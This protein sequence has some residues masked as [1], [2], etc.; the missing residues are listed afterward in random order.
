LSS[1]VVVLSAQLT[2]FPLSAGVPRVFRLPSDMSPMQSQDGSCNRVSAKT[3]PS[4]P[5]AGA[6]TWAPQRQRQVRS[7]EQKYSPRHGRAPKR[8]VC[9]HLTATLLSNQGFYFSSIKE[10]A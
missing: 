4:W 5:V 8:Y 2:F 9:S 6:A 7:P 10:Y 1:A 3:S